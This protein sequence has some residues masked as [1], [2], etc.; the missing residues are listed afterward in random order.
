MERPLKDLM[1]TESPSKNATLGFLEWG[2]EMGRRIRGFDWSNTPI[3]APETWP[4][5][6][7]T[8]VR[9][10]LANRFP[11]LLWWGPDY[12]CIYNDAY[13]P[14]LGRKHPGGLG[15]PVRE[16]WSEIWD[17]LKPLIDTP[18]NGGPPTWSEDIELQLNRS[19]FTE[20]THFMIAYSPVPDETTLGG[21][22]G[23]LA[24]VHES[25]EKVLGQ[26][27]V[28]ILHDLATST[29][30]AKTAEEA[31]ET[32]ALTLGRFAKDIPFALLYL[33]DD[34]GRQARLAASCGVAVDTDLSPVVVGFDDTARWPMFRVQDTG[35]MEAVDNL[36]ARFDKVPGG[37]WPDPPDNAVI[38]PIRAGLRHH[39]AGYLVAGLSSR[40]RFDDEYNN[41][42]DLATS[43]IGT[44]I[45]NAKA[46]EEERKRA[47][48]LAEIDRAKTLFFSN[49]SHEFRTPI[50]LLLGPLEDALS[51][52]HE[53]SG[54][55]REQLEVAHRNSLRL[56]RLV[57]SLLDFSRLE[58]G[59]VNAVYEPTDLSVVTADLAS[60]FRSATDRAGLMLTVDC[61]PLREPVYVDQDMWEKIVLNLLSNA[62]KFT[63]LGSIAVR[64]REAGDHVEL[65]VT[66]TGTGI[67]EAELPN[68]FTRFHRIR[69]AR[70]R[71]HE[72][73]G[74]GL[75]L[76]HELARLHGGSVRVESVVDQQ[77]TF[78][79]SVPFGNAHLPPEQVGSVRSADSTAIRA[80]AF[81][82]EALRWLPEPTYRRDTKRV[83]TEVGALDKGELRETAN[84]ERIDRVLL[85]DDNADM[86]D[87]LYR[88]LAGSYHVMTATRGD[89]ALRIVLSERPDLVLADVMMPGMD[90]FEL[91]R[92]IR[93]NPATKTMLVI[94]LSARAG[95]EARTEGMKAGADDYLVKPFSAREV[96]ARV[97]AHL[98]LSRVRREA[99][100]A[101]KDS[102]DRLAMAQAI[103]RAGSFD[104]DLNTNA[105]FLSE[106]LQQLYG[107]FPSN[108]PGVSMND[109]VEW[110]LPDDRERVIADFAAGSEKEG[111]I[112]Q[113]RI[114]RSDTGE[115]RWIEARGR[116]LR[117]THGTPV[118][119]MGFSIDVSEQ[120]LA[121]DALRAS[122]VRERARAAELEGILDTAPVAMF[123]ARD[124]EARH[125][126]GSRMTYEMLRLP[127]DTNL[128]WKSR[129]TP[130]PFRVMHNGRE[131]SYRDLPVPKAASAGQVI[132]DY[133][134]EL[135]YEDGTRRNMLGDTVPLF[136][137][138]GCPR[139]SVGAF[140][141]IT[142]R[143]R[144]EEGM[145]Q[146][147]KL[148]SVGTL[149]NGIAHDFN[150]L[151]GGVLAQAELAL[152]ELQSGSLPTNE[153]KAIRDVAIRGSEIVRELM[154]YAGAENQ[155]LVLLDVSQVIEEMLELL[156]ISVSKNARIETDLARDLPPIFA[157]SARI[158]QLLMNLVTNASEAI[159]DRRGVIR[160]STR[161]LAQ[162]DF[163]GKPLEIDSNSVQLEISDTGSGMPPEMLARVFEPFFS[164]KSPGRGLGLA[165]VDG[166]V[167]SL[168]GVVQAESE[169]G[170]GTTIRIALPSFGTE[171]ATVREATPDK[172]DAPRHSHVTVLLVE[173]EAPLRKA[174]GKMLGN[175]GL[176]VIAAQDGGAAL[177]IIRTQQRAVDVLVLDITIPGASSREVIEEALRL[178][179]AMK[180]IVTSAY[181]EDMATA[182]LQGPIQQF[183]RK[184]YHLADLVDLILR[185]SS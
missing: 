99:A 164:T 40:L 158:S 34:S 25:T 82:E 51:N 153:L 178:R 118:R 1:G 93:S 15:H 182:S 44:A 69:G 155:T 61:S 163:P 64:L 179:P 38:L 105:V 8:T 18:F 7:R 72:G 139:G 83:T 117:D 55:L 42:L 110:I 67:P 3:G 10:L 71:T 79:V 128:S 5:A 21:I 171:S 183:V 120:K 17:I 77:T 84:H 134:F 140:V 81:V 45:A 12:I 35:R 132:R 87:Y 124:R 173:D 70:A 102:R 119:M 74:I 47:E 88:L 162:H 78:T 96:L 174:V 54:V 43:Q 169:P 49:V 133:E 170:K 37:P 58:A 24:T 104:L 73:T 53:L 130:P 115:V 30:D 185:T 126:A 103:A 150:N 76:V 154:I 31:C 129:D 6:L 181:T 85:V 166:I 161:L 107:V 165:V 46:Y 90:G 114:R 63:F 125:I 145:R 26:R 180:V 157:N 108:Q 152:V 111:V 80:E 109:W 167:R 20:E 89:E 33:I 36:S 151:L 168:G 27:R 148:E 91:L 95:D 121:E 11:M 2:G 141:D 137:A 144:N 32:A 16:V 136:D 146:T 123:I 41:F 143:K 68:V 66:D 48:A 106:E 156:K 160:V 138:Q 100:E 29:A 14:I 122:E 28:S 159:G 92:A 98:D 116:T 127:P 101:L 59:R 149:A 147:Q 19:G 184:P 65:T 142:E 22:G 75:A 97:G 172:I 50:T 135:I 9:I 86:H 57:N 94:L 175:V 4:P 39:F 56:L 52:G 113:F 62:F 131:V 23:V 112:T 13:V 176:S 177:D 60:S